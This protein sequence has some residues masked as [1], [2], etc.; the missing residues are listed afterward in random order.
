VRTLPGANSTASWFRVRSPALLGKSFPSQWPGLL[1]SSSNGPL[2]EN[3]YRVGAE[4]R[5]KLAGS[6]S[7]H[8]STFRI[9]YRIDEEGHTVTVVQVKHRRDAYGPGSHP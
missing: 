6:Y 3:P 9:Q 4:L 8:L 5:G 2:L 7:A 1:S